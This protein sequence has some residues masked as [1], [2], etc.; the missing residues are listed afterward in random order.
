MS[1]LEGRC[2]GSI[3]VDETRNSTTYRR[4][5]CEFPVLATAW[6]ECLPLLLPIENPDSREPIQRGRF[7]SDWLAY[8][9]RPC[10]PGNP[11]V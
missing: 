1:E 11:A 9:T 2:K 5:E 7:R 4:P 6:T 8:T 10:G 3:G